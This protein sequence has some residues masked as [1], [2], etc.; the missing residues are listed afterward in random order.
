GEVPVRGRRAVRLGAHVHHAVPGRG[1]DE[2]AHPRSA[3]SLGR[4]R[5]AVALPRDALDV[6]RAPL[7]EGMVVAHRVEATPARAALPIH[8]RARDARESAPPDGPQPLDDDARLPAARL[9]AR[10]PP[11]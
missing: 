10:P 11:R 5:I 9:A 2:P 7:A 8:T 4:E 6:D 3:R 1:V